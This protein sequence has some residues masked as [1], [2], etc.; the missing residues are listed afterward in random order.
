M[1]SLL[2]VHVTFKLTIIIAVVNVGGS[3]S[4]FIQCGHAHQ[5]PLDF[6]WLLSSK[7]NHIEPGRLVMGICPPSMQPDL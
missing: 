2:H 5:R 6:C 1:S 7:H 4:N 3:V